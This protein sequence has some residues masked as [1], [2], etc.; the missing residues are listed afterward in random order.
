VPKGWIAAE[1]LRSG[2]RLVTPP[3]RPRRGAP[4][5]LVGWDEALDRV[6]AE[7][8]PPAEGTRQRRGRRVRRRADQREGVL[9]RRVRPR[10]PAH[11]NINCNGRLCT[12]PAAAAATRAFGIDRGLPFPLAD[13]AAAA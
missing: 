6:A 8:G 9:A 2:E 11:P 13:L 12:P 5:P 3:A 10:R 1:L 7:I 4:L